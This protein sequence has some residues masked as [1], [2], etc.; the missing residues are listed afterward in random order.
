MWGWSKKAETS[1]S[2]LESERTRLAT[3]VEFLETKR[4]DAD[5]AYRRAIASKAPR[6]RL[7]TLLE[8]RQSFDRRIHTAARLQNKVMHHGFP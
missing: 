8:T 4:L 7:R 2:A 5:T 3:T 1:R 6:A